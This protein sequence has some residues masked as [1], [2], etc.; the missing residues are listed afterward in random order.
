MIKRPVC[1]VPR[2][3]GPSQSD[4]DTW[5]PTLAVDGASILAAAPLRR[6]AAVKLPRGG[7]VVEAREWVP[8][9]VRT[10]R[11]LGLKVQ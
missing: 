6:P 1:L 7:V 9:E 3:A 4:L 5:L 8:F 2:A 11:L 10:A